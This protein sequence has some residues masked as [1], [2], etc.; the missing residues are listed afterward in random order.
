MKKKKNITT[1]SA[2][3]QKKK[4]RKLK[5]W[6]KNTLKLF[7][8]FLILLFIGSLYYKKIYRTVNV[9][10]VYLDNDKLYVKI[11]SKLNKNIYCLLT[12]S[13]EVPTLESNEW[14]KMI[15]NKCMF[16]FINNHYNLYVK[17]EDKLIYANNKNKVLDFEFI[18]DRK[19][20]AN[21]SEYTLNTNIKYIGK[22]PNIKWTSSDD[23]IVT[24]ENGKIKTISDGNV[25][26]K[27][28]YDGLFK[29]LDIVSTSLIVNRPKTYDYKKK[30][31]PCEK[32]SENENDL[33]D[34]ILN[35][36]ANQVGFETRASAVETARFLTLEFP[37]RINYFYENGRLTQANK[38]DG[39]GRY[40]HVGMY[41]NSSRYKD[42]KKSTS[43][44]KIW[45]CS[46]Y[47]NPVHRNVDNGLDCSGFVSWAL[48]NA[49]FDVGD[50]GAGVSNV[51]NLSQSLGEFK[52]SSVSLTKKLK[53]GD[54]LFSYKAGGHIGMLVGID[55]DYFYTA[56]ALWTGQ[57]GVIITKATASELVKEFPKFVLM[58]KFYKEDGNLT[59]MWY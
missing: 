16:D 57:I 13:E 33:I 41:L 3:Y 31:L 20:F 45:G 37:Y 12:E 44:P 8:L 53:V 14:V 29:K 32:Y 54:L 42:I 51:K 34:E 28:E 35:Y 23:K 36:R 18:D 52:D 47:D 25:T 49:G 1:R 56:Q 38:I 17:N 26:I 21:N 58:D 43:K 55:D 10:D 4:K 27:A 6:V 46:L 7:V 22:N 9:K 19:Y 5:R 30:Y 11:N 48:L 59:N 15:D 39:E 24:V 40:Y 50:L 2:K